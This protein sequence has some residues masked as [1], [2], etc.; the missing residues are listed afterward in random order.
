M[1]SL[2]V[3]SDFESDLIGGLFGC[4]LDQI[5]AKGPTKTAL[6]HLCSSWTVTTRLTKS[7]FRSAAVNLRLW[8]VVSNATGSNSQTVR[9]LW[10]NMML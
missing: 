3:T 5:N 1:M 6:L 10:M 7:K 9:R 2:N 8:R 4:D